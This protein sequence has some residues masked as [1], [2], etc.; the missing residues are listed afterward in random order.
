V[1]ASPKELRN[2]TTHSKINKTK[3]SII[4]QVIVGLIFLAAISIIV[5]IPLLSSADASFAKIFKNLITWILNTLTHLESLP[6]RLLAIA[7]IVSLLVGLTHYWNKTIKPFFKLSQPSEGKKSENSII[8]GIVLGGILGLYLLFIGIQI[9]T[10]FISHLPTNF[11]ET[12]NLVKSGFWQLFALTIINILFYVG[13]FRKSTTTVQRILAVFTLASLLLIVSA[14]HRVFMYVTI[15]GLSYEKFFAFYTVVF[16]SIVFVWFLSLFTYQKDK[17]VMIV[18]IFSFLALWMYALAVI[19]P[20]EQ[21]IF[22]TNLRLTQQE[23]SRININ[24]LRML[25]FD[26]LPIVEENFDILMAEARKDYPSRRQNNMSILEKKNYTDYDKNK[27][28]NEN[29][30]ESWER[31]IKKQQEKRL[32]LNTR[33]FKDCDESASSG[34]INCS[35]DQGSISHLKCQATKYK[36]WYE[37]TLKELFYTSPDINFENKKYSIIE[38][39]IKTFKNSVHGF[40]VEYS[41]DL[42]ITTNDEYRNKTN[43]TELLKHDFVVTIEDE[44]TKDFLKIKYFDLRR[45]D[46]S[47]LNKYQRG[48]IKWIHDSELPTTTLSNLPDTTVYAAMIHGMCNGKSGTRWTKSHRLYM[49][50]PEKLL[51]ICSSKE[52]P[53]HINYMDKFASSE[54]IDLIAT[55]KEFANIIKSF[56]LTDSKEKEESL[57]STF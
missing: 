12:E 19:I 8:I 15:Y 54:Y 32:I 26:A 31:W 53:K 5:I 3:T 57:L 20:L 46:P 55:T 13:V 1:F 45:P 51:I 38:P 44:K 17:P 56:K 25:G 34:Y 29:V 33:N 11:K 6:A 40:S 10:L 4:T 27:N 2:K 21:F 16:C 18:K 47:N 37:H 41:K 43:L 35:C 48:K 39:E 22:S 30:N 23:N 28:L 52:T 7:I 24:E 49:V 14:A 36:K 42:R 50:F 9:H